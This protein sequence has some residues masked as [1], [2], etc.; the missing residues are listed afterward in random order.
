MNY[1]IHIV[2]KMRLIDTVLKELNQPVIFENPDFNINEISSEFYLNVEH[3][4]PRD[5]PTLNIILS[6]FD[7]QID[8]DRV[9][10]AFM[11]TNKQIKEEEE[12]IKVTV[13]MLFTSNI[14]IEYCGSNYT[15][16]Y[17]Y[18]SKGVCVKILRYITGLYLKFN[19]KTRDYN[20][21]YTA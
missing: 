1:N 7:I 6:N 13:K 14:K 9:N 20:S 18:N 12:E 19:C 11:W 2:E 4:T 8:I 16:L 3:H 17:F 5:T 21:I 15:K 10:E